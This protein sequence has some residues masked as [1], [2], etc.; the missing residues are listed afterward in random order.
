VTPE[1]WRRVKEIFAAASEMDPARVEAY[2]DEA[3]A[4]DAPLRAEV[5]SLLGAHTA[6]DAIVDRPAAAHAARDLLGTGEDRW[7]GRRIGAYEITALLGH[8][9]MGEVYRARR[10]DAEYEKEVAIKL[11][12]GGFHA[13]HVLQRFR[14][15][16]QILAGLDHPNIARLIDGGMTDDG[17]PY[18]V[19]ELVE[20]E[21]LDRFA[22]ERG[23][24]LRDRL[25]LFLAV[26]AA[27]SYAHQRLVVHRDLK[28]GNV[29]VTA[30][31]TVK[32]LD[33]GIA[34]LLQPAG[35]E[36]TAAPTA[37]L[38]RTLTPGFSSPEQI[39][40]RTI[41]TSSDVYSLGVVLYVLLTGRSPYRRALENAED[42][43]REVCDTEPLR[44]SAAVAETA[45]ADGEPLGRDL[46]AIILCALRK[47]PE[48]RYATVDQFA[49]DI[50]CYL[51]GR[52]VLARGEDL[53]YRA[54]KFIRR[55]RLEVGAAA[56]LVVTL[57]AATVFSLREARVADAERAR[58][59]RHFASVRG[60]ANSFLFEVHDAI[61]DL[62]GSTRGREQLVGTALEYLGA[63]SAEAGDDYALRQEL[64]AAYEKVGD[65]QG[66]AYGAAT[67][68]EPAAASESY[69]RAIAL[70]EPIV[71]ADPAAH[72]ARG[73]L[74]RVLLRRSR[75]MLLLEKPEDAAKLSGRAVS[76]S[77]A[78][79]RDRPDDAAR[80]ML[81]DAYTAHAY[82][83]DMTGGQDGTGIEFARKSIAIL[84]DL[85]RRNPD[86]LDTAYKLATAYSSL[87]ITILGSDPRPETLDESLVFY[88][89]AVAVDERLVAETAGSNAKYARGLV[90][91]R[92]NIA[93]VLNE[94]GDYQGAFESARK[95]QQLL[96]A[97]R[98]DTANKQ[99]R[100][101]GA[102]LAW[103]LGRALLGLGRVDEARVVFE[104][105]FT[106]LESIVKE[107]DTL[108]VHYLLG[109]N[110]FGLGET[111]ARL[112]ATARTNRAARLAELRHARRWYGVA[113]PHFERV[114]SSITLD[115][116]D[117]KPVTGAI[118]GLA[119]AE[120]EI[121]RLEDVT[122]AR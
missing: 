64:A 74:A 84:E 49:A 5:A 18:L 82:T 10:V 12:P 22:A 99:A 96:P 69:A 94:K 89:K 52:P 8:G 51:D 24:G 75:L 11:V 86:D 97:L 44:P 80:A 34:K 119:R 6:E 87:A 40:G 115:H 79:V 93:F 104:E 73:A 54:G 63:L 25:S 71:A 16:R 15:E 108:K 100:I 118:A 90:L 30:A 91:D 4:G 48:R 67:A 3:C 42:A 46:D 1:R 114:T 33:F 65:I 50:R 98:A 122:G 39:L 43:I 70:L 68:G 85:E 113:T 13:T 9:G 32:L 109:T 83:A 35:A 110:A 120:A 47:E 59:E 112:A 105:A 14:A 57:V 62:P 45:R 56:A 21:P 103:P 38:M 28:P 31:G 55:H 66:Q 111:H 88:R 26:C 29:L 81:A 106:E 107:S 92:F 77:E 78:L 76:M 37:T 58:A 121:A 116:M 95:A 72:E 19:M 7:L 53:S 102:N 23:L 20:G 41:T 17:A 60:L 117:M 2:L 101:D 27:V 36:S 61:K